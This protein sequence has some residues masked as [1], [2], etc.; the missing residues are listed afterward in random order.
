MVVGTTTSLLLSM[1]EKS[2]QICTGLQ[3]QVIEE[4]RDLLNMISLLDSIPL[5]KLGRS[6]WIDCKEYL[7]DSKTALSLMPE[8]ASQFIMP[9]IMF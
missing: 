9:N 4:F 2:P 3:I 8:S 7:P 1:R 5:R 6:I